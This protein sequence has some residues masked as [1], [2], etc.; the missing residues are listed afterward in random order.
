V[1]IAPQVTD[2]VSIAGAIVGG[3]LIGA[4]AYIAQKMLKD[5]LG[6]II[7]FDY[8]VTGTW[9]DPTIKRIPRPVPEA[10]VWP[11]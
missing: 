1:R 11:E 6:Q 4:A 9:S 8:D 7:T 10:Q 3:P 5:P 2:T